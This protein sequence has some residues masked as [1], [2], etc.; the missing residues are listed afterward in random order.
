MALVF[1][2]F[3]CLGAL[4]FVLLIIFVITEIGRLRKNVDLNFIDIIDLKDRVRKVEENA[5]SG[6]R[7]QERRF[8]V[9]R[10]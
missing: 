7:I 10:H 3:A 4:T 8:R 1:F 5:E 2:L 9:A 6:L